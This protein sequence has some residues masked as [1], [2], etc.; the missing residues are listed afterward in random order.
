MICVYLTILLFFL[1]SIV[2]LVID[3]RK[4]NSGVMT[5]AEYSF[6]LAIDL[7]IFYIIIQAYFDLPHWHLNFSF[8]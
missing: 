5:L 1:L 7:I 2:S 4:F 3:F 8:S 6:S